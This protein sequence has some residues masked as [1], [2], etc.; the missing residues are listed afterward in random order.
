MDYREIENR[1]ARN[2]EMIKER[3]NERI[4]QAILAADKPPRSSLYARLWA[5]LGEFRQRPAQP[6]PRLLNPQARLE[7]H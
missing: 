7:R 5:W 6:Q 4:A 1:L 2:R 3:E